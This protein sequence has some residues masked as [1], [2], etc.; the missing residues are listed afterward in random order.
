MLIGLFL[1]GRPYPLF[2]AMFT[3]A[4]ATHDPFYG[5][6]AFLLVAIGNVA[7]MAVLFVALALLGGQRLQR[8]TAAASGRAAALT[9][10]A[11][12]VAAVFTLAY[13]DLRLG[14]RFG[15]GWFPTLPWT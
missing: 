11:L 6:A 4:A 9:G 8:W 1:I 10:T 14:A 15:Y 5:A 2:K 3:Y 12:L 13:W 7:L